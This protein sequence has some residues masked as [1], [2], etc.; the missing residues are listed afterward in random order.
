MKDTGKGD[1]L[2]CCQPL[3]IAIVIMVEQGTSL[4]D[5]IYAINHRVWC[6]CTLASQSQLTAAR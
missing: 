5:N 4:I 1:T 6:G 3:D 2:I